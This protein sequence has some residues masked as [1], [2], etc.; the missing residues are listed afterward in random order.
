MLLGHWIEMRSIFQ[1]Q[2]ALKELAKLLP[3]TALR[4]TGG[5]ETEEVPVDR[6]RDGDLLLIRP[7]ASIPAD[8]VVKSGKSSVNEAM[9]TGES[10]PVDKQDGEK[11]I[12]G[13]VNGDRVRCASR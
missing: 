11:V 7:G 5:G 13:T 9:I 12:A 4:L 6:L 3:D 10:K 1:A 8:G 2:G